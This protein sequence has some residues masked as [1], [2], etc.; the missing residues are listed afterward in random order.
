MSAQ[1]QSSGIGWC[2]SGREGTA[3]WGEPKTLIYFISYERNALAAVKSSRLM[4][5]RRLVTIVL[6]ASEWE[7]RLC[8]VFH[9]LL[10]LQTVGFGGK[11]EVVVC[12]PLA[13]SS[14]SSSISFPVKR[15][16][17]EFWCVLFSSDDS[18]NALTY[19]IFLFLSC[20]PQLREATFARTL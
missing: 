20:P 3:R 13:Q 15:A 9:L 11:T 8:I 12:G 7:E 16:V 5:S 10:T 19:V 1:I 2:I 17:I 6:A 18:W 14:G 4:A